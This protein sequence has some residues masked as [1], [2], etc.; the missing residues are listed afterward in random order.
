[1]DMIEASGG[2]Y[3]ILWFNEDAGTWES[4]AGYEES[5]IVGAKLEHFSD[6][7]IE[8]QKIDP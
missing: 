4:I 2:S 6:Y 7:G 3:D 1:M 8:H 5:G